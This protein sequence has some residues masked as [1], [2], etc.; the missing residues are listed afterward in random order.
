MSYLCPAC[1]HVARKRSSRM[2]SREVREGYYSCTND[3]C[4]GQFRTLEG[5]PVWTAKPASLGKL[6]YRLK[7]S[8]RK[9]PP[10]DKRQMALPIP[11]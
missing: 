10:T 1:G 11:E 6:E 8:P 3:Q 4:C 5:D 9:F 2:L 7:L